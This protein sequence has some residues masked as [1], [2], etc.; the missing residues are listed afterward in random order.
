M[1]WVHNLM[2]DLNN[3]MST[4]NCFF[5]MKTAS[6]S[7]LLI[8]FDELIRVTKKLIQKYARESPTSWRG[9]MYESLPKPPTCHP[10]PLGNPGHLSRVKLSTVGNLT[11]NE[12]R[13]VGHQTFVSK[14]LSAVQMWWDDLQ[15]N[16][17]NRA[18]GVEK[19]KATQQRKK[20]EK[21]M[22][23]FLHKRA[24]FADFLKCLRC[25]EILEIINRRVFKYI[26]YLIC[27]QF[28]LE[29]LRAF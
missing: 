6:Y 18:R 25:Q 9:L 1:T 5:D 20:Q 4:A 26:V 16:A 13:P 2:S 29:H 23:L 19:A 24:N 10:P 8:S 15:Q 3:R 22:T 28:F 27:S 11:Q 17:L 14:R 12:A 7:S 21:K